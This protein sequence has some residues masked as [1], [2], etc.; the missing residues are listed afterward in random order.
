M[1]QEFKSQR[2]EVAEKLLACDFVKSKIINGTRKV[3]MT[4]D[5]RIRLG[6]AIKFYEEGKK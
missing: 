5:K 2:E 6:K 3:T 4:Y 1:N